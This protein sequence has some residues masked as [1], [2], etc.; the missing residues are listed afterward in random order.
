M[1]TVL[2]VGLLVV[3]NVICLLVIF[4]GAGLCCWGA[5]LRFACCLALIYFS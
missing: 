2:V 3:F 4:V 5:L 1:F